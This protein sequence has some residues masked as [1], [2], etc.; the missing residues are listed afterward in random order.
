M[1]HSRANR[2]Q[3]GIFFVLLAAVFGCGQPSNPEPR[4]TYTPYPTLAPLP[5]HTPR[6]TYTPYPAA[7][8]K[9]AIVTDGPGRMVR[10][11]SLGCR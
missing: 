6:P 5:T 4:P 1:A 2:A 7:T 10:G 3:L 9:P 11:P 8:P